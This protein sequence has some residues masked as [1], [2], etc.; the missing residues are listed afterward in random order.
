[1]VTFQVQVPEANEAAFIN[2]IRSL[3]SLGVITSFEAPGT[4]ARPG[5]P[6]SIEN[7]LEL[8]EGSEQQI[9]AGDFV[10]FQRR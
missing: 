1:M 5:A 9:A 10:Y 2:I 4:L 7:L 8:L 3:Q 6:V